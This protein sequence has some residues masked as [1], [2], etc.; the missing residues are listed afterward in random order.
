MICS[1]LTNDTIYKNISIM[2]NIQTPYSISIGEQNIYVLTPHFKFFKR[3][4]INDNEL[5][6]TKK[7]SVDEFHCHVSNCG[8]YSFK[9]LRIYKIHSNYDD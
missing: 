6:K 2:G 4:R 9:K 5:L 1:F 8:K 3:E 7:T